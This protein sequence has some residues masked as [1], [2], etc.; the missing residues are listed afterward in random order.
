MITGKS[1][2]VVENRSLC[3]RY[4]NPDMVMVVLKVM[5]TPLTFDSPLEPH[6]NKYFHEY[7]CHNTLNQ[8]P[9]ISGVNWPKTSCSTW[10]SLTM[11]TNILSN[12][13]SARP[14]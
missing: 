2:L 8:L 14:R 5:E 12:A 3:L 13:L 4:F 1:A 10:R 7:L 11:K 9:F 6:R